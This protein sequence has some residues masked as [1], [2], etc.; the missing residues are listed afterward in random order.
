MM[1][2]VLE[3]LLIPKWL[4][5]VAAIAIL[6][7]G[8]WYLLD[9]FEDNEIKTL[10][11]GVVSGLVV[12]VLTF[13]TQVQPL[14]K[15]QEFQKTG[16]IALRDG[17]YDE[18]YYSLILKKARSR[19]DV[20]GTSCSRFL[21]DFLD[22]KANRHVLLDA[23]RKN[24]TLKVRLLVPNSENMSEQSRKKF[25]AEERIVDSVS[26]ELPEQFKVQYLSNPASH[27]FVMTDNDFIGGPVF[28]EDQS[29]DSPALH[30]AASTDYATKHQ[31]YFEYL[32]GQSSDKFES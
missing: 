7:F 5:L 27:S 3:S 13:A 23:M 16:L 30:I 21:R 8:L 11:T 1:Q 25:Q 10:I 29:K 32:W 6:A 20:T 22:G 24:G 2:N 12:W 9:H 18:N 14:K 17:R 31:S 19:V 15:L 28:P 26:K 4:L